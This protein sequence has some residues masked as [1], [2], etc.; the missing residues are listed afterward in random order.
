[1]IGRNETSTLRLA[2]WLVRGCGAVTLVFSIVLAAT[3]AMA[4]QSAGMAERNHVSPS[5]PMRIVEQR[6][7]A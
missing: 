7:F 3:T 6:R 5:D 1:M 4:Q 2:G